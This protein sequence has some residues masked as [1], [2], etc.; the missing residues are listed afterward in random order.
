MGACGLK[1][2]G[3]QNSASKETFK[4][5]IAYET[6]AAA[7]QARE[8][9]D[10]VSI[11]MDADCDP[12]PFELLEVAHVRNLAL[13]AAATADLI[14]VAARGGTDLPAGVKDWLESGLR[15][16]ESGPVA[17]VAL[18][19]E[20]WAKS[21]SLPPLCAYLQPIA[22]KRN[23][24]FF[25][26]VGRPLRRGKRAEDKWSPEPEANWPVVEY[27]SEQERISPDGTEAF[28]EAVPVP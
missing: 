13:P 14:I 27:A 5:A 12:W 28:K 20:D 26:D 9:A 19:E 17:L 10:R 7:V 4:I 8:L 21:T 24:S 6:L 18:V 22:E 23:A 1:L 3:V 2:A 16:R 11:C 15:Q 25:W